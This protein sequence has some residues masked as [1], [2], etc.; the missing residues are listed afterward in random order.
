MIL[1][2]S[3]SFAFTPYAKIHVTSVRTPLDWSTP[4]TLASTIFINYNIG[5]FYHTGLIGHVFL[6]YQCEE[7]QTPEFIG[8]D[9]ADMSEVIKDITN[10]GYAYS[11]FFKNY[12]GKIESSTELKK[13]FSSVKS[14]NFPFDSL[15]LQ[16]NSKQ[17]QKILKNAAK[18]RKR[19]KVIYKLNGGLGP[20]AE[21]SS[22]ILSLLKNSN[23]NVVDSL[24]K[25]WIKT[26]YIPK[27]MLGTDDQ[28]IS[29]TYFIKNKKLSWGKKTDKDVLEFQIIEPDTVRRWIQQNRLQSSKI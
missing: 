13:F 29:H 24:I 11:I 22:F 23:V 17:C 18:E 12:K 15:T 19:K 28:K 26:L 27:S 20:D 5:Q 9:F 25:K 10:K 3:A 4:N 21:C 2:H 1:F 8:K 14:M 16:L 7:K 6:E